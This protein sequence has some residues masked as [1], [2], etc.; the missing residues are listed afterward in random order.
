MK[1]NP[2]SKHLPIWA[3]AVI[4]ALLLGV[5]LCV[6]ALFH[7][8]LPQAYSSAPISPAFPGDSASLYTDI[9]GTRFDHL[10]SDGEITATENSYRSRDIYVTVTKKE[11]NGITYYVED[12]YVRYLGNLRTA[13][14]QDTYGKGFTEYPVDIA[15]RVEAVCAV[16][17]DYYGSRPTQGA[18]IRNGI[19]YLTAKHFSDVCVLH[20]DGTMS[21]VNKATYN[22]L[23]SRSLK[24]VYQAW[25]FGPTL[26][27]N[28]VARKGQTGS[29]AGKN[30][31]SGIGYYEPG[32]YCFVTVDGRQPGYSVGATFDEF[33][34]IFEQLGCTYA[35]NLDGGQTAVMAFGDRLVNSPTKGGRESSDIICVLELPKLS[36][37]TEE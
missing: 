21:G 29:L 22:L 24:N 1:T 15:A 25:S 20:T 17:G 35:Y 7:H 3:M 23:L 5:G 31:R 33:A 32:H 8:V 37:Q 34:Q 6:F 11:Q 18:I 13:F 19:T 27:E 28:G 30:P 4:D 10:F 14:A 26:V 9:A 16:N 36:P 2:P 12:I